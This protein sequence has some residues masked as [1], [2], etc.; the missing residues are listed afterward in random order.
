MWSVYSCVACSVVSDLQMKRAE[1]FPPAWS[2][3][4][5]W[6]Y[7]WPL[8]QISSV[9][10]FFVSPLTFVRCNTSA[11]YCARH[12]TLCTSC[13]FNQWTQLSSFWFHLY[14][15]VWNAFTLHFFHVFRLPPRD[16]IKGSADSLCMC[17]DGC[18][19]SFVSNFPSICF[20][21]QRWP[22][23]R[24][25]SLPRAGLSASCVPL[26]C[27]FWFSLLPASSGGTK[28]ANTQ[29]RKPQEITRFRFYIPACERV[30][31]LCSFC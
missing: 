16:D 28:G 17:Y 5:L 26:P 11:P 10:A 19:S 25:T 14:A 15:F 27:L 12:K 20:H 18:I 22:A 9:V 6:T 1:F 3:V 30:L 23:G 31:K 4:T 29:V 2:A 24:W 13:F 8:C 7:Y 21:S